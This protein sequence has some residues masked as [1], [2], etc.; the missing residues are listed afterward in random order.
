MLKSTRS[1]QGKVT[2]ELWASQSLMD[3][4]CVPEPNLPMLSL[5]CLL[6]IKAGL[7]R[8]SFYLQ[9]QG[10][11][12]HKSTLIHDLVKYVFRVNHWVLLLLRPTAMSP[13]GCSKGLQYL[14]QF[15]GE[16]LCCAPVYPI[17]CMRE[18]VPPSTPALQLRQC[19]N[20]VYFM[21]S[22]LRV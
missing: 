3:A 17:V 13:K 1:L 8:V 9:F 11:R 2:G 7:G 4:P 16:E 20:L 5:C 6:H 19:Y 15:P 14:S 12:S 18:G 22:I 21:I 10:E